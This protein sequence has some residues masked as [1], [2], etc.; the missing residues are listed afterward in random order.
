M[1][2][3]AGVVQG[4]ATYQFVRGPDGRSY[5]VGGEVSID[6]SEGNTPQETIR[7]AQ[8]IRAAALAPQDPSAQDRAVAARATQM[9]SQARIKLAADKDE[10]GPAG[11]T[12]DRQAAGSGDGQGFAVRQALQGYTAQEPSRNAL[13]S[14]TA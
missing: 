6:V 2:A 12:P 8:Q 13:F 11:S 9:E 14:T 1:S 5:A 4:G 10:S 7:K 3:G